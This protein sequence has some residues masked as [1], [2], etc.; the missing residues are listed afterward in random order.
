VTGDRAIAP[1]SIELPA[2][3]SLDLTPLVELL[4]G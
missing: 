1:E 3:S 2:T 4:L